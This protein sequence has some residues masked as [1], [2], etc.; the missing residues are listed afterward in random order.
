MTPLTIPSW[1]KA[2]PNSKRVLTHLQEKAKNNSSIFFDPLTLARS[3]QTLA[4]SICFLN[5]CFL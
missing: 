3:I 4:L 1:G 2:L 5:A